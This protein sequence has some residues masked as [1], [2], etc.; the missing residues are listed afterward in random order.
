[1][2][3]PHNHLELS[4]RLTRLLEGAID[5]AEVQAL[6]KLL[7]EDEE[8]LRYYIDYLL[9]C[10]G[11][12][13]SGDVLAS[14]RNDEPDDGTLLLSVLEQERLA[15]RRR[16]EEEAARREAAKRAA[17]ERRAAYT[18]LDREP[19][20][21]Y[22]HIVIPRSLVYALTGALAAMVLVVVYLALR[23]E[24]GPVPG[25]V[26]VVATPVATLS[27]A[28]GA[29]WA[30]PHG[31]LALRSRLTPGP[32]R[33]LSGVVEITFDSGATALIE[34]PAEFELISRDRCRL[35]SGKLLGEVPR[36]AIGFAVT[37]R[38]ASVIDL[39]TEFGVRIGPEGETDVHVFEGEVQVTPDAG[40]ATPAARKIVPAGDAV[41]VDGSGMAMRAV[42]LDES[43]F[44]RRREFDARVRAE[45]GSRYHAWLA[46]SLMLRRRADLIAYYPFESRDE[47]ELFNRAM[48][49]GLSTPGQVLGATWTDGRV[50]GKGALR[51]SRKGDHAVS[52]VDFGNAL[53]NRVQ[54]VSVM[55]WFRVDKLANSQGLVQIGPGSDGVSEV[56]CD[57]NNQGLHMT[58]AIPGYDG[59]LLIPSTLPHRPFAI[60][61][62][63]HLA[64]AWHMAVIVFDGRAEQ[65]NLRIYIDGK[66][67]ATFTT[68][69]RTIDLTGAPIRL[70]DV[71]HPQGQDFQYRGL[72]DEVAVFSTALTERQIA[73]LYEMGQV[74]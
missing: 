10:G 70:G 33:L 73:E 32:M 49:G 14:Q 52:L 36:Q 21:P 39:G 61:D 51:F 1:M 71:V 43:A 67:A 20:P 35:L 44:V 7:R 66:L 8:A 30:E 60:A 19:A 18:Y 34:G 24:P 54:Q 11:L 57:F 74:K 48:H 58:M 26:A 45:Q 23:S 16:A 64:G 42:T 3:L 69:P 13:T 47:G 28:T 22:R 68:G 27:E 9:V 56:T 38:S 63:A 37:T 41:S 53:G 5:E 2:T 65:N 62:A 17:L 72:I 31:S 29:V 46:Y 4:E 12:H 15:A 59:P 6:E 50:P 40:N 55:T 25:Q